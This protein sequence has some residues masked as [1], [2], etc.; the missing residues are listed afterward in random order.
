MVAFCEVLRTLSTPVLRLWSLAFT[1]GNMTAGVLSRCSGCFAL[2]ELTLNLGLGL[3]PDD[4]LLWGVSDSKRTW[5]T[6]DS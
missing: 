4:G 5:A 3:L 2:H 6:V 1:C